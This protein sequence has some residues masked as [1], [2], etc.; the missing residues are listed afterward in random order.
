MDL[1]ERLRC[2]NCGLLSY[3]EEAW[4]GTYM[5]FYFGIRCVRE[6]FYIRS[7]RTDAADI[8]VNVVV[9]EPIVA[10]VTLGP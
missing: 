2:R 9:A 8:V 3:Q 7:A 10:V 1:D 5:R 6:N 4:W